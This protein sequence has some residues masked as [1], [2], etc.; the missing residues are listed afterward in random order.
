MTQILFP[1]KHPQSN[2]SSIGFSSHKI[3]TSYDVVPQY[4]LLILMGSRY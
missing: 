1:A 2:L 3:A 4:I